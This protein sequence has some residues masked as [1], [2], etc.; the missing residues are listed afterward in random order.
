MSVPIGDGR[1]LETI[2]CAT[3]VA[4]KLAKINADKFWN[5][6]CIRYGP[7]ILSHSCVAGITVIIPCWYVEQKNVEK[8]PMN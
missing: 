6:S 2:Q 8:P 3:C 7:S 5:M 1:F 4:G